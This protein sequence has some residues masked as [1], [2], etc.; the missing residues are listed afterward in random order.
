VSFAA[1]YLGAGGFGMRIR[2]NGGFPYILG[3]GRD[4]KLSA[5]AKEEHVKS[6]A[7]GE[8]TTRN[9][10]TKQTASIPGVKIEI[11]SGGSTRDPC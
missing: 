9:L 6:E 7:R 11:R 3:T 4:R 5:V 10:G 1:S 2:P 8:I